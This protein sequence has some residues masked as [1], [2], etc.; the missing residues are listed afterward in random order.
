MQKQ[1]AR[2]FVGYKMPIQ[3]FQKWNILKNFEMTFVIRSKK[4]Y[5]FIGVIM[6]TWL[7]IM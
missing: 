4:K 7:F 6:M 2:L 5:L 1:L 3:N